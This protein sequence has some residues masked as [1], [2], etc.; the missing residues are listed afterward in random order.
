[1]KNSN[2]IQLI[3]RRDTLNINLLISLDDALFYL[4]NLLST[5]IKNAEDPLLFMN[6]LI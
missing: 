1:M 5:A 3:C 4:L 6:G 2:K